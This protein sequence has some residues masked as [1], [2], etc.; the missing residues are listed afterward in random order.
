MQYEISSGT[1]TNAVTM[2][3]TYTGNISR[4]AR[5]KS[6]IITVIVFIFVFF[7]KSY[8]V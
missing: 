8:N 7:L 5:A 6:L 2:A 1:S 3:I 4:S